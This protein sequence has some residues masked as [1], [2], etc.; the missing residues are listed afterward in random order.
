[1]SSGGLGD[2]GAVRV[3][4]LPGPV[5][6]FILGLLGSL[7]V[8]AVTLLA[9]SVARSGVPLW[10]AAIYLVAWLWNAYWWGWQ[11]PLRVEVHPNGLLT[12][13]SAVGRRT[14]VPADALRSVQLSALRSVR[15]L[16]DGGSIWLLPIAPVAQLVAYLRAERPEVMVDVPD[17]VTRVR[18]WP[19][20][21]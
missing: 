19:W 17:W 15:V 16:H 20:G 13:T 7:G 5:R 11:T 10:F 21:R 18:G 4:Q 2:D 14:V 1:M 8:A 9:A 12:F 6:P 3:L